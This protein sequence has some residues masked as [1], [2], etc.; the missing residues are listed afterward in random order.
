[1]WRDGG[2]GV[3]VAIRVEWDLLWGPVIVVNYE[4]GGVVCVFFGNHS[5]PLDGF[6]SRVVICGVW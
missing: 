2:E 3:Y 4:D 6:H 1:M 5:R